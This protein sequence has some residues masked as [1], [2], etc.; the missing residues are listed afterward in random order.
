MTLVYVDF[1]FSFFQALVVLLSRFSQAEC[2]TFAFTGLS[3]KQT[4]RLLDLILHVLITP[5]GFAPN[6][7]PQENI[8]VVNAPPCLTEANFRQATGDILS[9]LYAIAAK[10]SEVIQVSV[11]W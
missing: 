3:D 11:W 8:P 10:Y 1:L 2:Q 9:P 6:P 7:N 5:Y 4:S